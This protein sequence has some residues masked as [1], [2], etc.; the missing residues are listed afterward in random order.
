M[1]KLSTAIL[2]G[3]K[4][5]KRCTGVLSRDG[6]DRVCAL[7]AACRGAKIPFDYTALR[8]RF[9]ELDYVP[10]RSKCD[11]EHLVI[12]LNDNRGYSFK[13]TAAWLKK[14]GY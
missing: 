10:K 7:G 4:G 1:M 2:K 8:G 11:L 9:P 6:G 5:V 12:N 13:R 14:R 3:S